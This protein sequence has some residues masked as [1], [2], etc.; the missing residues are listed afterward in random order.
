MQIAQEII[1]EIINQIVTTLGNGL[2][3]SGIA[4]KD[5]QGKVVSLEVSQSGERIFLGLDDTKGSY[6]YIR[7][8][9]LSVEARVAAANRFGSCG[10]EMSVRIPFKLV[11]MHRC[12]DPK[13]L[14]ESFKFALYSTN[15][16]SFYTDFKVSNIT[17]FPVSSNAISWE[18]Y[19]QETGRD[20]NTLQSTLQ[21]I[22]IDFILQFQHT[23]NN[24]CVDFKIC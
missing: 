20:A 19:V 24:L 13:K 9:G 16:K 21:I 23:Y 5:S 12:D 18:I 7:Q 11:A 8:S 6:F 2:T 22:S 10:N 14:L 15:L 3:G 4:I 1:Q 17:L